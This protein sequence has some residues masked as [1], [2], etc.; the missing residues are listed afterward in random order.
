ML[1]TE[2]RDTA[3]GQLL[4]IPKGVAFFPN[5]L[6]PALPISWELSSH[7]DD[8]SRAVA[9]IAGRA[10]LIPN[11]DLVIQPLLLRE[12]M[13]SARLEGTHTQVEDILLHEAGGPPKDRE[14]A[15]NNL[16]VIRYRQ[17][18]NMGEEWIVAG[19]DTST[20]LV[21]ALH[22]ELLR[23]TRGSDRRPGEFRTRQVLIGNPGD[24]PS[25]ARFVP[26]PPEHVGSAMEEL[27]GYVRTGRKYPPLVDAAL[28][29]YQFETIHPFEDGNG[30]LGRLLISLQML[31]RG[32][33]TRPLLHLSPY[34][35]RHRTDYLQFMK[36]VSTE[37]AWENWLRFFLVGVLEQSLDAGERVTRILDLQEDYRQR[38]RGVGRSRVP[39][40]ALDLVL[41]QVIVSVPDVAEFAKCEYRTAKNA[42]HAL[43]SA[44]IVSAIPN[45]YPQ[46]WRAQE[47]LREVYES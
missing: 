39:L 30:R 42:V 38:I 4:P 20:Y 31:S 10:S 25:E 13:E 19:R 2:F 8:A 23:D 9:A 46:W 12:A 7:L 47:L 5:P 32:T 6:P 34:F 15:L 1:A 29:H 14:R 33:L 43:A 45:T 40:E 16:E 44:G 28:V 22:A 37:G 24:S 26:P 21:R 18:L 17:A 35:E 36:Q 3:P 27:F 11:L 41:R